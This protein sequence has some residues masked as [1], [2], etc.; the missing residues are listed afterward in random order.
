MDGKWI[1]VDNGIVYVLEGSPDPKIKL[2]PAFSPGTLTGSLR[3]NTPKGAGTGR[4]I[5]AYDPATGKSLWTHEEDSDI[6]VGYLGISNGKLFFF[7]ER[8]HAGCLDAKT[9]KL[10]WSND[11]DVVLPNRIWNNWTEPIQTEPGNPSGLCRMLCAPEAVY[12]SRSDQVALSAA[13]GRLL[14][15]SKRDN[16]GRRSGADYMLGI[17]NSLY[18]HTG[19]LDKL[20]GKP[21]TDSKGPQNAGVGGC[22]QHTASPAGLFSNLGEVFY[23]FANQRVSMGGPLVKTPCNLGMLVANGLMTSL[24]SGCTCDNQIKGFVAFSSAQDVAINPATRLER[25]T[26][27][28]EKVAP[29]PAGPK[30]WPVYRGNP[31][32]SGS[33]PVSIPAKAASVW[34]YQPSHPFV[35]ETCPATLTLDTEHKPT[36]AVCAGGSVFYAGTDGLVRC[37]DGRT[38]KQKWSFAADGPVFACP[39]FWQ[40]RLYVGSADGFAYSLEAATG[41]L[42]WRFRGAPSPRRILV[43]GYLQS[44]WPVNTGVLVQ[45]D[46]AYFAAGMLDGM[47]TYVYALK[48]KTGESIWQ[49][50]T[51][52]HAYSKNFRRGVTP[53]GNMLIANGQLWLRSW[54]GLTTSY[55]L[56]TGQLDMEGDLAKGG[57]TVEMLRPYKA[58]LSGR[59]MGLVDNRL[60]VYGGFPVYGVDQNQHWD[61]DS[62]VNSRRGFRFDFAEIDAA[63]KALYAAKRQEKAGQKTGFADFRDLRELTYPVQGRSEGTGREK[64]APEFPMRRWSL[65]RETNAVALAANAVVVAGGIRKD[66][67]RRAGYLEIVPFAKWEVAALDRNDGKILWQL[68]LPSEPLT[69]GLSLDND[70]NIIVMLRDGG[71]VC[72][73][74]KK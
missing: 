23:D 22:N 50:D 37:L 49:N 71:V 35:N 47:G 26:G 21:V 64:K 30:D 24:P 19:V 32:C 39:T 72:V 62:V 66:I 54:Y 28:L 51:S 41:R 56:K 15:S 1:A 18:T 68:D 3:D 16:E 58:G 29:L 20:T 7:S 25:G 57:R 45:D 5:A 59:D 52:G 11:K 60:L 61:S 38:G 53:G 55:N 8:P 73:G 14:W 46:A 12:I 48:A 9:G 42:L 70:G 43:Y 34:N 63:G 27:D 67:G 17:G 2:P 13:D 65:N 44:S 36:A 33:S 10:A 31:Q 6:A 74:A 4:R 40:D 69:G